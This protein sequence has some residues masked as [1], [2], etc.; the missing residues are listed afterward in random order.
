MIYIQVKLTLLCIITKSDAFTFTGYK[1]GVRIG[2][3]L[4]NDTKYS[5]LYA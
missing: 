1:C 2:V 5:R 3:K 4:K